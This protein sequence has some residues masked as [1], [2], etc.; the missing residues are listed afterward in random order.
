MKKSLLICSLFLII[1]VISQSGFQAANA[2]KPADPNAAAKAALA[3]NPRKV[4]VTV[5]GEDINEGQ[6]LKAIKPL[7]E[8]S[9]S[10][11]GE[12]LSQ[13]A[14]DN[15]KSRELN[16]LIPMTI[17]N[18]QVKAKN[19]VVNDSEIDEYIKKML[20]TTDPPMTLDDLKKQIADQNMTYEVWKERV[21]FKINKQMEKLL[22]IENAD[23]M[24]ITDD[25]IKKQY[26]ENKQVFQRPE[27]VRARHILITYD[28]SDP[29]K[30]EASKAE[31]K[32]KAQD[33]LYRVR[34]GADF[35][36]MAKQYSN[37]T[38]SAVRGGDLGY[39][40]QNT[41]VPEFAKA[42]FNLKPGQLSE[43][44]ETQYGFHII[45]VLDRRP[46]MSVPYEIARLRIIDGLTNRNLQTLAPVYIQK[47][48]DQAKIAYPPDSEI[49]A[50]EPSAKSMIRQPTAIPSSPTQQKATAPQTGTTT[51]PK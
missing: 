46:P 34:Q 20:T 36:E 19:V 32:K 29:N 43:L 37:D 21:G 9:I 44:V 17:F 42:S 8:A 4:L 15:L 40:D 47:L 22:T 13:T 3:V 41:M 1:G 26:D 35:N 24:K 12:R 14:I 25:E 27:Q 6:V 30:I 10:G 48:R 49:R 38:Q 50:Y 39:F 16:G 2:V 31:A 18:Q 5:N 51:P 11:E 45:K 7:L 28:R 23:Q 33:V